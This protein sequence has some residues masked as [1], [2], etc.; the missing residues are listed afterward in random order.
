MISWG[1]YLTRGYLPISTLKVDKSVGESEEDNNVQDIRVKK[2]LSRVEIALK[3]LGVTPFSTSILIQ[4]IS[5]QLQQG[6]SKKLNHVLNY[7]LQLISSRSVLSLEE[8]FYRLRKGCAQIIPNLTSRPFWSTD[9]F[10][11][12]LQFQSYHHIILEEFYQLKEKIIQEKEKVLGNAYSSLVTENEVR[13]P[14]ET[15]KPSQ[16]DFKQMNTNETTK[17]LKLGFQQYSSPRGSSLGD[18]DYSSHSSDVSNHH[19][20]A[21]DRGRWNVCYFYLN[22]INFE[23]NIQNCPRTI[24]AIK[25]IPRQYYHCMFSVRPDNIPITFSSSLIL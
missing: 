1:E 9:D 18:N 10:P 13:Q 5:S 2:V 6:N 14:M 12:I 11:W 17:K 22:G 20:N 24:E 21:T 19:N 7:L 16:N 23:E 3:G 15:S 8:D 4:F 25:S